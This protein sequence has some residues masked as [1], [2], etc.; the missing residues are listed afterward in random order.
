MKYVFILML[1]VLVS[2]SPYNCA[3]NESLAPEIEAISIETIILAGPE[4]NEIL[5]FNSTV[6]F[7]WD[8]QIK[9]GY[10][11]GFTYSLAQVI[12]DTTSQIID[13]YDSILVRSFSRPN[14]KNGQYR[15]M[16]YA[17]GIDRDS[18]YVDDTPEFV[19]FQVDEADSL[20]PVMTILYGPKE[21]SY[22]ASG[23][24]MFFEWTA[25]DPSPGGAIVSYSYALADSSLKE[26]E[27]SWSQP[28]FETTQMVY[29][30]LTDGTYRF[31]IRASDVSE[32]T[33]T[34]TRDFVVKPADILFV[35]DRGLDELTI[36]FWHQF[37]LPDFACED[38]YLTANPADFLNKIDASE[39]S[40]I[41]WAG[42][43]RT[44]ILDG[45]EFAKADS[46][47]SLAEALD[48]Y[49]DN[50]GHLWINGSEILYD[51][52]GNTWPGG[53]Y[54]DNSFVKDV[55]HIIA[56]D[57]SGDNFQGGISTGIEGYNTVIV[58]GNA[59]FSWC[60]RV[61]PDPGVSETILTFDSPDAGFMGQSAAVRFP[62][63]VTLPGETKV[64]FFGFSLTD[65]SDPEAPKA[66]KTDDI[67]QLATTILR[68]FG[69]N[70][71]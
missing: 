67:Y 20:A 60:D 25:S 39:Y 38:F 7:T 12:D 9:P 53:T 28:R 59:T 33:T 55:L 23:A 66:V 43:T 40:S 17:Y 49:I 50:G 22:V 31:W 10:I 1:L 8:G 36:D 3:E 63:G 64:I 18:S 4:E 70:L 48:Q 65:Y 41:V 62:A 26:T 51:L 68:D 11:S 16:V 56:S 21:D 24:D 13:H 15:F 29:D 47:G 61:D 54:E 35:I 30:N 46:V 37:V 69:E 44:S 42:N 6:T 27:V 5:A 57:E 71:D 2:V 58:D 32:M 14:M 19:N 34:I 45:G 52:G